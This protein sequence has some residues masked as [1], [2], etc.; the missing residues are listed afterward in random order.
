MGIEKGLVGDCGSYSCDIVY[1]VPFKEYIWG[2]IQ[3]LD[4]QV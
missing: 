2:F 1:F 3:L 4:D